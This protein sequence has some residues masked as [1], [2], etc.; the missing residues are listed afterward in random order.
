VESGGGLTSQASRKSG[1]GSTKHVRRRKIAQPFSPDQQLRALE[2]RLRVAEATDLCP[3][4]IGVAYG[5][6]AQPLRAPATNTR[7]PLSVR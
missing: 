6:G 7:S 5:A 4:P 2:P 1:A 3:R